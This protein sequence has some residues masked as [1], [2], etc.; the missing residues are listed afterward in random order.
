MDKA[1]VLD[2]TLLRRT[3]ATCL[4]EEYSDV[5]LEH[6]LV[7]ACAMQLIQNPS[8]FKVFVADIP[9]DQD[10]L[11]LASMGLLPSASL[12]GVPLEVRCWRECAS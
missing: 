7:D 8:R 10:W 12:A 9:T 11:L 5:G 3:V 4:G 1:N 2:C 6:V